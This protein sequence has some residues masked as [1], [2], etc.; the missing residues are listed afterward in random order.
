MSLTSK[1]VFYGRENKENGGTLK[2]NL[3][4]LEMQRWDKPTE[5]AQ[6][7]DEKNGVKMFNN[8]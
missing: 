6:R 5:R 7:V 4:V 3:E 2:W 1:C 8:W